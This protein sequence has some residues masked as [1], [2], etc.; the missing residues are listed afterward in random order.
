[1][2]PVVGAVRVAE[3]GSV[4]G[5]EEGDVVYDETVVEKRREK[6]LVES[7][8]LAD[9]PTRNR[10]R[11]GDDHELQ[12]EAFRFT[13][14]DDPG[15][16]ED[17]SDNVGLGHSFLRSMER[18][19]LALVYVVD[20]P[21]PAP[22]DEH[23]M[24]REEL[25]KYKIGL[26]RRARIVIDNQADPFAADGSDM[27]EVRMARAKLARFEEFMREEMDHNDWVLDGVPISGQY[28]QN[29]GS[30]HVL[31]SFRPAHSLTL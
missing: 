13:I 12:V 31:L 24:L 9:L 6:E 25:E 16:I 14:A 21:G 8:A 19:P 15:I 5:G 4:F 3:D 27:E 26:S 17:A 2:N 1:L 30:V 10:A 18:S 22:W 11:G 7:G 28:G 29:L 20:L 23:R